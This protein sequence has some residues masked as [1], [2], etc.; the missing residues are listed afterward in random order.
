M[1]V[2]PSEGRRKGSRFLAIAALVSIPVFAVIF[3]LTYRML[4]PFSP[5]AGFAVALAGLG[6]VGYLAWIF[7]R[8]RN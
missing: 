5:V 7:H 6:S 3:F 4:N 1:R 2:V 8:A